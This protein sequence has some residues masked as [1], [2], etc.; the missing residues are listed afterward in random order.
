MKSKVVLAL[1]VAFLS[2]VWLVYALSSAPATGEFVPTLLSD[3]NQT[4]PGGISN[5]HS[6]ATQDTVHLIWA[7]TTTTTYPYD[8]DLFYR[9]LPTGNTIDLS[10]TALTNGKL[11]PALIQPTT[12]NDVCVLWREIGPDDAYHLYL[13]RSASNKTAVSPGTVNQGYFDY[14]FEL[15][16][17][18]CDNAGD[19]R[20]SWIDPVD[21]QVFYWDVEANSQM[22]ISASDGNLAN[23]LKQINFDNV[24][25]LFWT[26]GQ[27]GAANAFY[28]WD[29]I[30]ENV[31]QITSGS[32]SNPEI[33]VDKNDTIHLIWKFSPPMGATCYR[34]WDSLYKVESAIEP[35]DVDL[36]ATKD[37]VG[38]L[39]SVWAGGYLSSNTIHYWNVT[40]NI[41]DS[42]SLSGGV[43]RLQI[44]GGPN[45]TVHL[46]WQNPYNGDLYYSNSDLLTEQFITEAS[47]YILQD[48]TVW[49]IDSSGN[50]HF[51]W[52]DAKD[53]SESRHVF[54]WTPNQTEPVTLTL[55]TLPFPTV[56]IHID[57][58]DTVHA[59]AYSQSSL[60][61]WNDQ[62]DHMQTIVGNVKEYLLTSDAD[63]EALAFY[64]TYL[65]EFNYWS[66]VTENVEQLGYSDEFYDIHDAS[67]SLYLYW[68]ESPLYSS[69]ED[70][71]VVSK[72]IRSSD[73]AIYLPIIIN[74]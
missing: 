6:I 9:R 29:S 71:Y 39:H 15:P 60:Y 13:W 24:S 67:D 61:Y 23:F 63:G 18:Y 2:L 68:V 51:I 66:S 40:E 26:K 58:Q 36:I 53:G 62:I 32:F 25:Y 35:C 31:Q 44:I 8:S 22:Q 1:S 16:A 20:V 12:G 49:D 57:N 48:N 14:L 19:A 34:H 11:G 56:D 52:A 46:I 73:Y 43:D 4:V 45:D 5:I 28:M 50:I 64:Q 42:I 37:G 10:Q 17:F 3:K 55:S 54:Y 69:E 41:T 70:M 27:N 59:L 30:T 33:Y 65:D 47:Y 38:N 21:N 74:P 7:E 72:E